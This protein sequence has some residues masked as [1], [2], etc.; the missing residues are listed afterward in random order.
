MVLHQLGEVALRHQISKLVIGDA[1][2]DEAHVHAAVSGQAE[3][4][5]HGLVNGQIGRGD[6]HGV[7]RPADELQKQILRRVVGIVVGAV[8]HR[9]AEALRR[10]MVQRAVVVV[11]VLRLAAHALPHL[12]KR[13]GQTPGALALQPHAAV[14]PVAEALDEVGVLVGDIGA[15]GIGHVAVHAGDL[16]VVAVVE[17]QAVDIV[18]NG[19]E[20]L[21][22]HAGVLQL[23]HLLVGHTHHA[24]EVVENEL[25]LH[26]LPALAAEDLRQ[27]IPYLPLG[28]DEILHKNE[29]LGGVQ[30]RQHIVEVCLAGGQ[31]VQ[32]RVPVER[33]S[34]SVEIGGHGVPLGRGLPQLL[35]IGAGELLLRQRLLDGHRLLQTQALGRPVAVPQQVEDQPHHRHEQHQNDPA[36]FV[37][38]GA[39]ARPYPHGHHARQ[40][41]QHR[42]GQRHA[43]LQKVA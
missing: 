9:L 23:L 12:Q 38:G 1:G 31:I 24:A 19:V 4:L 36:H 3:R 32:L 40:Q 7:P 28:H 39:G 30:H 25:D 13:A 41:L 5:E 37:A 21:H 11:L 29:P 42:I 15:A 35:Q 20:Y 10:G 14:L 17:V 2:H 8:H 43:L 22:L 16:P 27:A 33:E 34:L 26:S 18:V 6:I